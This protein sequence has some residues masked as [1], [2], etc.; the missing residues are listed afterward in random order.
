VE[1]HYRRAVI[2]NIFSFAILS[3]ITIRPQS[4]YRRY[5]R[6]SLFGR[7]AITLS[8]PFRPLH[9]IRLAYLAFGRMESVFTEPA[10]SV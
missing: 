10:R 7:F 5:G 3:A 8:A 4:L 2:H 6:D 1:R 9:F